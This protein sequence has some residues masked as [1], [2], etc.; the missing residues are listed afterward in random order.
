MPQSDMTHRIKAFVAENFLF[1]EDRADIPE[2]ESLIEAGIIDS[3]GVLELVAYLEN[4]LGITVD[5]ADILPE[6]LDSIAAISAYVTR[7]LGTAAV[8]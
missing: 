3:T 6:N 4:D 7:K 5:D 1:R 2:T 8:A